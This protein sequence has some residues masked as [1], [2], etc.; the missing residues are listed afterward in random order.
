MFF[1]TGVF[2]I[3]MFSYAVVDKVCC[4]ANELLVQK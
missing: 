3:E 1:N 2:F 4:A